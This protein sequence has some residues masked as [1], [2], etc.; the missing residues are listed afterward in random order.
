MDNQISNVYSLDAVRTNKNIFSKKSDIQTYLKILSTSEL[1][2]E[3][4]RIISELQDGNHFS[5][6][7]KLKSK[8]ILKEFKQRL[9][10]TNFLMQKKFSKL[11]K[12]H[13]ELLNQI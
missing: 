5:S 8:L 12:Q 1:L 3:N 4:E 6:E 11:S 7:L 10:G 13:D 9:S 2:G